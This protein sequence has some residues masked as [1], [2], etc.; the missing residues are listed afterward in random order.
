MKGSL[1]LVLTDDGY[2]FLE[3]DPDGGCQVFTQPITEKQAQRWV[4]QGVPRRT[5]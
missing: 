1:W 3:F 4:S 5:A 2:W